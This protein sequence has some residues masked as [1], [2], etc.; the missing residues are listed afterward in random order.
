MK[1]TPL[2]NKHRLINMAIFAVIFTV[3]P[4]IFTSAVE[5][6]AP[7]EYFVDVQ[8]VDAG[9]MRQGEWLQEISLTRDVRKDLF[10]KTFQ[11]LRLTS[12]RDGVTTLFYKTKKTANPV[13][14]EVQSDNNVTFVRDWTQD[15]EVINKVTGEI[16]LEPRIPQY[17]LDSLNV[18]ELYYWTWVF[19]FDVTK[20]RTEIVTKQSNSWELLP[21]IDSGET[22]VIIELADIVEIIQ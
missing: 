22:K 7:V 15:V 16:M 5:K 8:G 3:M 20:N 2:K 10:G 9:T 21:A 4:F 13:L 6:F 19:E 14:F 1:K 12:E 18:G 17:I 11:E